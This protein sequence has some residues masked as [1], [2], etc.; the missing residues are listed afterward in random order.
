MD[1]TMQIFRNPEFGELGISFIGDSAY[2]PATECARL[3]G[4]SDPYDAI[5]RHTKGSVKRRVPTSGGV[6]EIKLIPEGDLYR[7][8]IHSRLPS[9]DRFE[10]WVFEEVLPSIRKTGLYASDDLVERLIGDPELGIRLLQAFKEEREKRRR[11]ESESVKKDRV[12]RDLT[13]K[14]SYYDLVLQNRSVIPISK[15]AKDYGMSGKAF[16]LLLHEL[17]VQYRMGDT[18]LLYQHLA[19][20]G[21][22]QSRTHIVDAGRS[23][24]RTCWTQKGRLFLYELLKNQRGILPLIERGVSA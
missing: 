10:A 11:L 6:Q 4:Y 1:N 21:Y 15:I 13:P 12:I 16:N 9:S 18:W 24:L 5:R 7:L 22:T 17:G 19:G 8:I 14:A 20:L 23:T 3:L 2:F